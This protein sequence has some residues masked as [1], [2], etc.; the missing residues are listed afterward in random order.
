[1]IDFFPRLKIGA[2][3]LATTF[4]IAGCSSESAPCNRTDYTGLLGASLAAT[5]LPSDAN[6]RVV[7]MGDG[8][9]MDFDPQR[10]NL[11]IDAAGR[12]ADVT[13]G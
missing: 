9:T 6:I 3:A 2:I 7:M 13:C 8:V 1:M 4:W 12:I 5:T 11:Q 10:V